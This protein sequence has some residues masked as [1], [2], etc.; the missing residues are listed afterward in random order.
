ML[1]PKRVLFLLL[2][3]SHQIIHFGSSSFTKLHLLHRVVLWLYW[4]DATLRLTII[5]FAALIIIVILIIVF[6]TIFI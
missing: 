3:A 2:F 5:V 4:S 6:I 1:C